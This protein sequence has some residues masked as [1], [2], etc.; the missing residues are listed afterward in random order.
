MRIC[1]MTV[2][3]NSVPDSAQTQLTPEEST[4]LFDLLSRW[5]EDNAINPVEAIIWN[6][7]IKKGAARNSAAYSKYAL[8]S[9]PLQASVPSFLWFPSS[10][11]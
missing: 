8:R 3:Q 4:V 10:S 9:L 7:E 11:R 6:G 5:C 1:L 2:E